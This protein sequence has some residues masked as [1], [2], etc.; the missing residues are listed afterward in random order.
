MSPQVVVADYGMGNVLSVCRA[1]EHC[2]GRVVLTGDTKKIENADRLVLPGVGAFADCAKTLDKCGLVGTIARF[3][4]TGRP[5]LG[6]CVG[7]Q[8]LLDHSEEFGLTKGLSAIPGNVAQI[9]TSG[10]N[11]S[12]RKIPHIG[13]AGLTVPNTANAD[14]WNNTILEN[15]KPHTYVYFVHSFSAAP[16]DP[17]HVLA[18]VDYQ[19]FAITAAVHH[20]NIFGTQFHP[21]KSGPAGLDILNRFL[22][23]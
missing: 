2:N 16:T 11:G 19:G 14:R 20:Q 4:E 22:L 3:I 6:I 8:I 5:F 10:S 17:A 7:M 15:T 12:A 9:P 13:W 23:I 21:E 1:I 18:A